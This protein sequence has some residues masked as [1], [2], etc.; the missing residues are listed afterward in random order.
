[1]SSEQ[2][3]LHH[4]SLEEMI[5]ESLSKLYGLYIAYHYKP[6]IRIQEFLVPSPRQLGHRKWKKNSYK[7]L[8]KF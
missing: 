6:R 5:T 8:T 7:I 3:S 2:T 1:M 4:P